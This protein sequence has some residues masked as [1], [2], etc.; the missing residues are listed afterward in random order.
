MARTVS[1]CSFIWQAAAQATGSWSPG[2]PLVQASGAPPRGSLCRYRSMSIICS[3]PGNLR[4]MRPGMRLVTLMSRISCR[5]CP[6]SLV[7]CSRQD[8]AGV[9]AVSAG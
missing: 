9:V 2:S 6:V 8:P 3:V 1:A 5:P 4:A 7:P